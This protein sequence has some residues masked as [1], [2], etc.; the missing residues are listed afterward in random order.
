MPHGYNT[1]SSAKRKRGATVSKARKPRAARLTGGVSTNS[2][3]ALKFTNV[4]T[5]GNSATVGYRPS[6]DKGLIKRKKLRKKETAK[7]QRQLAETL[8]QTTRK[9]SLTKTPGII[10]DHNISYGSTK[11]PKF[12]LGGETLVL[13]LGLGSYRPSINNHSSSRKA[14]SSTAYIMSCEV[15]MMYT[16]CAKL[17]YPKVDKAFLAEHAKIWNTNGPEPETII[18]SIAEAS[19][20][21]AVPKL[22]HV[23]YRLVQGFLKK[24][25]VKDIVL[26]QS[27][28]ALHAYEIQEAIHDAVSYDASLDYNSII[29]LRD[30]KFI[31]P[32]KAPITRDIGNEMP[33]RT[34][35][36]SGDV[37]IDIGKSVTPWRAP[38][39]SQPPLHFANDILNE[40]QDEFV[41][42]CG[43]FDFADI[44]RVVTKTVPTSGTRTGSSNFG[45]TL[46]NNHVA[47]IPFL[48]TDV[49]TEKFKWNYNELVNF[50]KIN[51]NIN[52][53]KI[54]FSCICLPEEAIN[55]GLFLKCIQ[56]SDKVIFKDLED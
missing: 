14:A 47:Y 48:T 55:L 11:S 26:Q 22:T 49:I 54:P 3:R 31:L 9:E 43:N 16:L 2:R 40:K 1:R 12:Y 53:S 15:D 24:D 18:G 20:T 30:Q 25:V 38:C 50:D 41:D 23:P 39:T 52:D 56:R 17:D 46:L 33:V 36:G 42:Q 51:H 4:R 19:L 7:L 34:D 8:V 13:P 6:V 28:K 44:Q 37:K 35:D 27:N 29:V 45:N 21:T 10:V 32:L 5:I